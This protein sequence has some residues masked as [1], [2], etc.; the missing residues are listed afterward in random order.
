MVAFTLTVVAAILATTS[1]RLRLE[2]PSPPVWR[3]PTA[4][5]LLLHARYL[6]LSFRFFL[7]MRCLY[8]KN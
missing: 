4:R 5:G 6:L 8:G 2:S 7:S 3:S 1:L